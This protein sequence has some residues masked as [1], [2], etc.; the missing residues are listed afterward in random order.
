MAILRNNRILAFGEVF[1]TSLNSSISFNVHFAVLLTCTW[2]NVPVAHATPTNSSA[3]QRSLRCAQG[4]H[5][6]YMHLV[7]Y[8]SFSLS[9]SP[10]CPPLFQMISAERIMGYSNIDSEAPLETL[11][12]HEKPSPAWP[13]KGEIVLDDVSF[14]YSVDLPLVLKSL[15][16][17]IK[18][19]EK[20]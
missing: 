16:F 12:P 9:S 6:E 18:P 1:E 3:A 8:G 19:S 14:R 7:L 20:V 17:H 5:C 13:E 11:P 10:L 2:L 4:I 15:S